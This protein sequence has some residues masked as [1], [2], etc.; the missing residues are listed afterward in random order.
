MLAATA[1][2]TGAGVLNVVGSDGDDVVKFLQSGK[3]IFIEGLAGYWS[4]SK[5]KSIYVDSKGG[6]DFVSL[7][8][9]GNGGNKALKETTT[10]I[11]GAGTDRVSVGAANDLYFSGQ[12]N[13]A[14]VD[15]KGNASLNNV[16]QNLASY[17]TGVLKSKVL[18]VA[19]TNGNDNLKF[20]QFNGKIYI[21]GVAGSFKASKVTS[22]VVRLQDGDDSVSLDSF[23]NGGNQALLEYVTVTSGAGGKTVRLANG[24]DVD[25]SGPGHV[26]QVT[27]Y[28]TTTLDGVALSWDDPA[29]DPDPTP[30]PDPTPPASNWFTTHIQDAAL[31]A[32]G[33]SLYTDNVINRSD[34]IALLT[35]AGDNGGVDATEFADL[36]AIVNNSTLFA[37]L[38]YVERLTEYVVLGSAANA[39]YLG[40]SLGNLAAGSTTAKLTNL[41]NKWFLGLDHPTASGTYR[42]FAGQLFVD[43]AAYTDVIQGQVG[44]CYLMAALAEAALR[45]PSTITNMFVVNGDGTY[46][47]KFFNYGQAEYVTVDAYLPTNSYGNAIYAGMGKNYANSGNEL[48]TMLAEKAYVQANQ[49]GWIRPGLPGNGQNAYT[50]IEGGYIYAATGHISGQS[51]IAFASTSSAS[52]FTT[53]VNAWNAG[54]LIG[55][56]SKPTPAS[57]SVVGSHAYAVIGYSSSNQT[58]TLYNPWGPNYATVTMTWAQIGGSFSYFDRTA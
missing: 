48:W 34:A 55:F 12:G 24:H 54:K 35:S 18:T 8:S 32:L 9:Y 27:P 50:G 21:S 38:G 51:T 25:M 49:F 17:A 46:T 43:G 37:G 1:T 6:D 4:A 20:A 14:R 26:L 44:D 2:L 22:I 23:A 15:S 42:Q 30:N 31:R 19:G 5:V 58:I 29:P 47:V 45:S 53:F 40:Q 7:N 11:G 36:Q 3:N 52:N 28:G 57:S 39:Q 56:A 10:I 16:A 13:F 33:S 41:V